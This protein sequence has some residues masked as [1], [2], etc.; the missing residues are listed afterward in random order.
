MN[1][2]CEVYLRI[3][4]NVTE[5]IL[6]E[7]NG[8]LSEDILV[9]H[10]EGKSPTEV[11]KKLKEIKEVLNS[12]RIGIREIT[13]RNYSVE[14]EVEKEV[15]EKFKVPFAG[16]EF[17]KKKIRLLYDELSERFVLRNCIER[18]IKLIREKIEK[19]Y[20]KG[21]KEFH[22]IIWVSK[23]KEHVWNKD[24]TEE[25]VKRG[26]LVQGP[27]KGKWFY[28]PQATALLRSMEKIVMEEVFKP[29]GFQ[30][31]IG[32][33][34][35]SGDI[36]IKT[37]HLMGMPMEIYYVTEPKSRSEEFWEDFI[38]VLKIT[39]EIPHEIFRK[40]VT[41]RPLKGL[42]YAQCP[43]IYWSF[44]NKVIDEND[45]PVLVMDRTQNSFRY[46]SGGR[47]GIERTDEFYRIEFVFIG[48]PE[49]VVE[50]KDKMIERYKYIFEEIL[51]LEWRMAEVIPFHLQHSGEIFEEDKCCKTIG[52][53]DFEAYLPY[54]GD[55]ETSE[56]LEF[57]NITIVGDKYTK[58]FNIKGQKSDLW[59]G[60]SGVGLNRWVAAFTAQKGL[61]EGNWPKK[62]MK[63]YRKQKGFILY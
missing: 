49:Q 58:A 31:V 30:E 26:W 55:R 38:D 44:K 53:I 41:L 16:I 21:K 63:Y 12:N 33:N 60:C 18:T 23:K 3:K 22:K 57:Q 11:P 59:S 29:L 17:S 10:L 13:F 14:F 48:T 47:H 9:I 2:E 25:M 32:S 34:I 6:K 8:K 27:T 15:L 5:E 52:T 54:R 62:F 35:I 20:Y 51:E 43:V 37:G 19:Q 61:D 28:R 50:I 36:W 46:E 24:P 45:L 56:W 42:T 40:K 4:G 7:L 1:Y 39:R